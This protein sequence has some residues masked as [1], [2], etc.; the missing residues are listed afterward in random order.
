MAVPFVALMG[1]AHALSGQL[2]QHG[3]RDLSVQGK[4]RAMAR[5]AADVRMIDHKQVESGGEVY[6]GMVGERLK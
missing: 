4:D 5:S 6:E 1:A 2:P 3:N